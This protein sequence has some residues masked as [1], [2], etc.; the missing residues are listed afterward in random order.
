MKTCFSAVALAAA[1]S[2][3]SALAADLPLRGLPLPPAP[4]PPAMWTG[5]YLGVNAGATFGGSPV[6]TGAAPAFAAPTWST[7]LAL[8]TALATAKY[9]TDDVRFL[10]G[11]QIGYN[12]QFAQSWVVGLEADIAGVAGSRTTGSSFGGGTPAAFPN[13]QIVSIASTTKTLDYFGTVRGRIGYL[14]TPSLLIF[15]TGG[16]AYGGV[17][18]TGAI[19][20]TNLPFGGIFASAGGYSDLRVG[21]TAGGGLEALIT[22]NWSVKLEYL[23][24]DLGKKSFGYTPLNFGGVYGSAPYASTRFDGHIA[25]IGLNYHFCVPTPGPVIAKY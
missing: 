13:E 3:G 15:G 5:F 18:A 12:F 17:G 2:A 23:Y 19:A 22:P 10:G 14:I 4:P 21:W 24:Y 20:Q 1:L 8:S 6:Y 11:A 7:E 16:F 25:R 9:P